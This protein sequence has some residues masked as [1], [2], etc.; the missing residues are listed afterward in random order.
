MGSGLRSNVVST[1]GWVGW[2][3]RGVLVVLGV[4]TFAALTVGCRSNVTPTVPPTVPVPSVTSTLT[5]TVPVT[6]VALVA[7][8]VEPDLL[9]PL[10]ETD[11][12]NIASLCHRNQYKG[13]DHRENPCR[14]PA[15]REV[16]FPT[17]SGGVTVTMWASRSTWDTDG[18]NGMHEDVL[19]FDDKGR[20]VHSLVQWKSS[21]TDGETNTLRRRYRFAELTGSGGDGEMCVESVT[22]IGPNRFDL[23]DATTFVPVKRFVGYDA[24]AWN[25]ER[26]ERAESLD[27]QCPQTGYELFVPLP[28]T[29]DIVHRSRDR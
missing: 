6:D 28:L 27:G 19:L 26:F 2:T 8:D 3:H 4:V 5:P 7:A 15:Q 12:Y 9:R 22:E 17:V 14:K 10:F 11:E 29:D 25:A 21:S 18:G 1:S 23:F 20:A 16:A 13:F 24:F